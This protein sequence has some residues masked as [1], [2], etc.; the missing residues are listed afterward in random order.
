MFSLDDRRRIL[1]TGGS[2]FLGSYLCET[3]L[4]AG[5]EVLCLDNFFT[6]AR[7]N[8]EHL[9]DHKR[10]ELLRMMCVSRYLWR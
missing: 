10:F 2:G 9:L 8:V 5:H 3:L 1:V 7:I 4:R 6:G